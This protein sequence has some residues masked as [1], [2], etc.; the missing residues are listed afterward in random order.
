MCGADVAHAALC[1]VQCSA[2]LERVDATRLCNT[3]TRCT[4]R[5]QV[6]AGRV[7]GDGVQ[8][9]GAARLHTVYQHG[10]RGQV[11]LVL[12]LLSSLRSSALLPPLLRSCVACAAP[13]SVASSMRHTRVRCAHTLFPTA[14]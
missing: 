4:R 2:E 11:S 9:R 6:R 14:E 8:L 13:V 5:S 1:R 7:L 3:E 12:S 10:R